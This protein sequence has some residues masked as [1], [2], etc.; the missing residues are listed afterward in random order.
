[1]AQRL[2]LALPEVHLPRGWLVS[3]TTAGPGVESSIQTTTSTK[4][5]HRYAGLNRFCAALLALAL[6]CGPA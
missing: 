6:Y 1:M 5:K 4:M 2:L 3:S